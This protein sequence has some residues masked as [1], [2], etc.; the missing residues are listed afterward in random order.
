MIVELATAISSWCLIPP[1][2]SE[3]LFEMGLRAVY[4]GYK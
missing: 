1:G 4:L 3:E 2:T